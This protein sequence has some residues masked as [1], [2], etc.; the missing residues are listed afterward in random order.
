MT[1]GKVF[2]HLCPDGCPTEP[3]EE[4]AGMYYRV[5]TSYP[6]PCADDFKSEAE[7]GNIPEYGSV[8][9]KCGLCAVSLMKEFSDVKRLMKRHQMLSPNQYVAE[10][11][12]TGGHGVVKHTLSRTYPSHH[13]WWVPV[14]V[15]PFQFKIHVLGGRFE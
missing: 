8:G 11:F 10:V 7:K 6:D 5:V 15:D 12:L 14:D 4:N 1:C 3:H 9:R 13:N 2:S